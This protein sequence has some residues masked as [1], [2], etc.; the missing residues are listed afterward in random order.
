MWPNRVQR[1]KK[2]MSFKEF[3]SLCF[4]DSGAGHV[5]QFCSASPIFPPT[6]YTHISFIL[7]RNWMCKDSLE[8]SFNVQCAHG[9]GE[10]FGASINTEKSECSMLSNV[11]IS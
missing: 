10:P 7:A 9:W 8:S 6:C 2:K 11:M 5:K 1:R 3:G 4:R